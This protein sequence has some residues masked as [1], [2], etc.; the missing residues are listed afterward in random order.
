MECVANFSEGRRSEVIDAIEAEVGGLLLDRTMDADHNRSVL[1]FAGEPEAVA[2]AAVRAIG[3]AAEL[4]DLNLHTGGHP[5]IGA[6]DVVPFV[7]VE[8]TTLAECAELAVH[9]GEQ[10]WHRYGVPVYLYEA[11]ARRPEHVRLEDIRRGQF[12]SLREE[13]RTDLSRR[14]DIGDP[15]LHP[16]AGATVMGARK[17]LIAFNIN[18]ATGDVNVAR[19]IARK[20]RQSSGGF[21]CVK[22][23]GIMLHSHAL[24]QVSMNLTD[25]EVT[26]LSVVIDAVERE[27]A[28]A[29]TSIAFTELIGLI[30][31]TLAPLS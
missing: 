29:G 12:E 16:T 19:A 18:L 11:A 23:L 26:P 22:A 20:I 2:G 3:K 10:V 21:P 9:A 31:Q 30:P 13:L 25:F 8:G 4:I 28:L 27:A 1:T 5:R 24:A 7:P 17:F 14:P 6:A 15:M